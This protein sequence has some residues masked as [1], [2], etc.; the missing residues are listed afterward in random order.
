MQRDPLP[1]S[2][3]PRA[4][5][6]DVGDT[7]AFFD[8]TAVARA[9]ADAGVTVAAPH[10]DAALPAAKRRYQRYM[11]QRLGDSD[12]WAVLMRGVLTGA[13][14]PDEAASAA[15]EPLRRAHLEFNFWR[16]VPDDLP[17]ALERARSQGLRLAVVSN[18]E[19]RL[20][21]L[22]ARLGLAPHFELALD[23]QIEGVHKPD[24]RIFTRALARLDIAAEQALYAGDIPEIDVLGARSAGMRAVLV[25]P[26]DH[27]QGGAWPRVPSVA[28]LIDLLLALPP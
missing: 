21:Q 5:L 27:H 20:D 23:S 25:D 11:T 3:R 26:H 1:L 15:L 24:P 8:A 17:A 12:G 22:L 28:R 18:S 19:G 6:L 9:L 4:L 14:L 2:R 10:L 7:L 16:R 13:G